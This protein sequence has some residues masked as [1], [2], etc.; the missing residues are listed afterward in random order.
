M[1][2]KFELIAIMMNFMMLPK[3]RRPSVTPRS[4]TPRSCSQ[5]NDV[6][7]VL[8]DIDRAIDRD[9][10]IGGVQRRRVVDPVAEIADDM[11]AVPQPKNDAVLLNGRDPAEQVRLFQPRGKRFVAERFDLGAGQQPGDRNAEFGAD[12]LRHAL[13]V[14]AEDL[15]ADTL[16]PKRG[17]GRARACFWRIGEDDEAGKHQFLLIGH[18][19]PLT[20]GLEFAPGDAERTKSVCAEPLEDFR[21]AGPRRVVERQKLGLAGLF[22]PDGELDDIFGRALG[23]QQAVALV[24]DEDRNAAP[25]KIERHLIDLGPAGIARRAGFDDRGIERVP[26]SGL[27]MAVEPGQVEHVLAVGARE[28]NLPREADLGFGERPGLVRA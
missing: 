7:R 26:Q 3:A 8:G 22:V 24:L 9:A 10:D 14:A 25:L 2:P 23:D 20:V 6:G 19:C 4:S 21:R 1:F 27:E 17:D 12:M 11:T 13:V 15:D 5:Q 18:R 16:G 28:R